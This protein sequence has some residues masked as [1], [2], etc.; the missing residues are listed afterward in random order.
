M[1]T[2]P[3]TAHVAL[4][5]METVLMWGGFLALQIA[6]TRFNRCT[7]AYGGL[8]AAEIVLAVGTSAFFAWQAR[9]SK[10]VP[11]L[12]GPYCAAFLCRQNGVRRAALMGATSVS[13]AMFRVRQRQ[14]MCALSAANH[15][16]APANQLAS[17]CTRIAVLVF[18]SLPSTKRET[19]T[20]VGLGTWKVTT[21]FQM[22]IADM[23]VGADSLLA[24]LPC[25]VFHPVIR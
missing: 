21:A 19:I 23:Y 22:A 25:C 11:P 15:S 13:T 2:R 1:S 14:N 7:G 24:L 9:R 20:R 12:F 8:F 17:Y 3:N 6:K 5:A 16:I 10:L 4:Q 18:H